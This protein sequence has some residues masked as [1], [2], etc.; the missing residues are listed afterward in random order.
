MSSNH[1]YAL[2]P[3]IKTLL[4]AAGVRYQDVLRRAGLPEDYLNRSVVRV[5][6]R[7][8]FDFVRAIEDSVDDPLFVI[9]SGRVGQRGVVL[10]AGLCLAL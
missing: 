4:A 9:R 1:G 10:R 6:A 7:Q 2:D 5:P 3:G 8:Y